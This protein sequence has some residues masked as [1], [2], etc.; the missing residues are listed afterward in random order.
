MKPVLNWI[1]ANLV[2][3]ICVV[4][5]LI[6]LPVAWFFSSRWNTEI[7]TE[8]EA[9]VGR[10]MQAIT[11]ARVDYTIPSYEPGGEPVSLA[12]EPNDALTRWFK[13]Q[14][15]QVK[16]QADALVERVIAFNKGEGADAQAVGRRPH[17]PLIER[18]FPAPQG[19]P[20]ERFYEMEDA[21]LGKR[22]R[23]NPYDALLKR[24]NAGG[25]PDAVRVAEAVENVRARE[26]EKFSATRQP[27][28]EEQAEI[29]K[30]LIERRIAEYQ[31]R[32]RDLS[33]YATTAVFESDQKKGAAIPTEQ[34]VGLYSREPARLRPMRFFLWQ[35]D[36]WTYTDL[37][38]AVRV[39]NTGTGNRPLNIV[40]APVKRI[41]SVSAREVE[42]V[43]ADPAAPD[44]MAGM[45]M[46]AAAAPTPAVPGG[47][48]TDPTVSITGRTRGDWNT[49]YD[50]RRAD[51]R[52]IVDSKRVDEV[53]RAFSATNLMT[54]LDMDIEQVDVWEHLREGY[55]YGPDHVVR[56]N[57]TIETLWLRPWTSKLMPEILRNALG[58][59][60]ETD[61]NADPNAANPG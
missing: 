15:E 28:P 58:V 48:V 2:A 44:P 26:L 19:D 21:L 13:A 50:V 43:F 32:A 36:L 20:T 14:R 42:G 4:V 22:G 59:P 33:V 60:S 8:R 51:M 54:V 35:W 9:E 52:L 31:S 16:G 3:V 34:L 53:I 27:T 10:E 5:V 47:L 18:L 56:L 46:G 61:P 23:T 24:I 7:K 45:G 11:Q 55:Y 37:L 40:Q 39:A 30:K 1:K 57:L 29:Q 12:T 38:E 49:L 6:A 41:E 17:T 25:P